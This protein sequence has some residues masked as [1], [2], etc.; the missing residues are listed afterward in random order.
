MLGA[1]LPISQV[2]AV[3]TCVAWAAAHLPLERMLQLE[4]PSNDSSAPLQP[5]EARPEEWTATR[6]LEALARRHNYK[7]AKA[8]RWDLNR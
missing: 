4:L 6:I 3:S 7:T 1:I 2:Q 5:G 8:G